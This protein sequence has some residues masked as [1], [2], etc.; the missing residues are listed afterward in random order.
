MKALV[1]TGPRQVEYRDEP[2]PVAAAD[3]IVVKVEAVG[4][5]G[6]DMHA[7]FGHDERRPAPLILGHEASGIALAGRYKGRRV[8]INPL[9]SCDR[10]D[11][12]LGGRANLCQTRQ[13]IS[14]PPRQGAFA[15]MVKIPESNI[16]P[17]PDD[18]TPSR[19]ALVEPIATALHGVCVAERALW[20]PLG[21]TSALVI[22]GGAV[23]LSAALVLTSR[24]ARNVTI[25][26]TNPGRRETAQN[27]NLFT[28][29]DTSV[30]GS[31]DDNAFGLVIDAVG[32]MV[33][34]KFASRMIRPGGV[35][36]HI[37]LM[38]NEEGI[39]IRKMTLQE[40]TFIG[41]Y[42][43]TM[44][45]FRAAIVAIHGGALGD[46]GWSDVRPLSEG[47]QAFS[48]LEAG[49]VDQAKIILHPDGA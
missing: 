8:V 11:N 12:C 39:N 37:G 9:V 7:Y 18:L 10:C 24:G 16:I 4:I 42:T 23:G 13:I 6:S 1:Y 41:T 29:V 2:D 45:D 22:G 5:C 44:V 38:D 21:E 3:E 28:V 40:V 49:R 17:I 19:A 47:P 33:T 27:E 43:Y 14:M 26:D 34:R 15:E 48:D 36:V 46:L 30:A 31:I 32:G 20:R 35:I 25:A